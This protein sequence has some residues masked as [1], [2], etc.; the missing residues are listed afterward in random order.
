ME[1]T[2]RGTGPQAHRSRAR[3][4]QEGPFDRLFVTGLE[5]VRSLR[6]G[7]VHQRILPPRCYTLAAP[8]ALCNPGSEMKCV[9]SI[10]H[11]NVA[12]AGIKRV[13]QFMGFSIHFL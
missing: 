6:N 1:D 2:R 13:V 5:R 9:A 12:L 10:T 7:Y 11:P 8:S 4:Y 3:C